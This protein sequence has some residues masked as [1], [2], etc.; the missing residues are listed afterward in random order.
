MV[1]FFPLLWN[2][3]ANKLYLTWRKMRLKCRTEWTSREVWLRKTLQRYLFS[4]N[5]SMSLSHCTSRVKL[6]VCL[7]SISLR[8]SI[9]LACQQPCKCRLRI[10]S[11]AN[12]GSTW[13]WRLS[14]ATQGAFLIVVLKLHIPL[15]FPDSDT[16]SFTCAPNREEYIP[17]GRTQSTGIKRQIQGRKER[18][19]EEKESEWVNK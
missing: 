13:A 18:R 12:L 10:S 1:I 6:R 19:K 14:Q 9:L 17:Q 4:I 8:R 7:C 5:S 15:L 3:F 11:T 16:V 2:N